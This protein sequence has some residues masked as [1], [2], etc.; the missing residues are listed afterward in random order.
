MLVKG[1]PAVYVW[2][3]SHYLCEILYS[4]QQKSLFKRSSNLLFADAFYGNMV[5]DIGGIDNYH[6]RSMAVLEKNKLWIKPEA[7]LAFSTYSWLGHVLL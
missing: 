1:A 6:T 7:S 2:L 3:D 5:A 4:A